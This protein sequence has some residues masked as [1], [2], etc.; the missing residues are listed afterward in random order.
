MRSR[1]TKKQLIPL[2]GALALV[3]AAVVCTGVFY[4]G[5]ARV[6]PASA[7][8]LQSLETETQDA[9]A[10]GV[11]E[12]DLSDPGSINVNGVTVKDGDIKIGAAGVYRMS[13]TLSDAQIEVNTKGKV[14]LELD[15]VHVTSGSGPALRVKNAKKIT[16]VLT[17][18]S[19]NSLA[20]SASGDADAAAL[21]SNDS[22]Y[23]TGAG[24]LTVTGNN[25]E[26]IA[27]DDSIVINGGTILVTAAG[28]GLAA[29][30]DITID[31]GDLTV[32]ARGDGLDSNG[33][34]HINGG[35]LVSFGGVSQGEG[36][37]DVRGDFVITGGTVIAGGS[38]M[39]AVGS[40]SRQTSVYVSS[41]SI[42]ASGTNLVLKRGAQEVFS[43][44]PGVAY[45]NVL[46][47]TNDLSNGV[48]YQA[49]AGGKACNVVPASR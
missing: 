6:Q 25:S 42:Q 36:G 3:V 10:K 1:S 49:T 7:E 2:V 38:L 8:A 43:F 40:D 11:V 24:T 26:G 14:Y 33:T 46:I 17:E 37:V 23:F 32:T 31:S 28:D 20:D 48:A 15:G 16:I 4:H 9:Y 39:A 30:D 21:S 41:A 44:T 35:K 5:A 27:C 19:S 47:S 13:G 29:N 22:L 18:G 45:E 34:V 12:L